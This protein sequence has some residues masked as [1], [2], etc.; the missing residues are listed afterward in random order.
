MFVALVV[1]TLSGIFSASLFLLAR[2]QVDRVVERAAFAYAGFAIGMSLQYFEPF[3]FALS[4]FLSNAIFLASMVVLSTALMARHGRRAPLVAMS[5]IVVV[6]LTALAWGLIG[7][8]NLTLR[9]AAASLG[10]AAVSGLLAYKLWRI[11]GPTLVDRILLGA[12][13]FITAGSVIRPA[14]IYLLQGGLGTEQLFFQSLYWLSLV[15]SAVFFLS[16][17]ALT[18]ISSASLDTIETLRTEAGTDM[19]SGALNRRGFEQGAIRLIR[20]AECQGQ[21]VSLVLAD[22]DHFKQVNDHFGH[23]CGDAAIRKFAEC[24]VEQAGADVLVGRLGGEEFAILAS[25]VA[26][27]AA[28]LMAEGMRVGLSLYALDGMPADRRLTA[29]FGVAQLTPSETL[30]SLVERADQALYAAKAAGRDRVRVSALPEEAR[31]GEEALEPARAGH[32][33]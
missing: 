19:L 22:L 17:I 28:R 2:H 21:P 16:I 13:V 14:V 33:H 15:L 26:A 24:L 23:A 25:G 32:G 5:A 29:S 6:A 8:P 10:F 31:E 30:A 27:P 7:E 1:P 18:L 12:A 3:G 11:S 4:R 20:K 9:V